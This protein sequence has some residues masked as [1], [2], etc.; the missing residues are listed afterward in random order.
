MRMRRL[1]VAGVA[2]GIAALLLAGCA[3]T[4]GESPGS[5]TP[6]TTTSVGNGAFIVETA[7]GSGAQRYPISAAGVPGAPAPVPWESGPAAEG[8]RL[9]DAVGPWALTATFVPPLTD[10]S[11]NTRLQVRDVVTGEMAHQLE[12]PGWCSGPDGAD[13][14][15]VLLDDMR[16]ARSTPLDGIEDATVTISSTETGQTLA[17]FGPFPALAAVRATSSPD[18]LV[19]ISYD[20][21]TM[22]HTAQRL[23]L[24]TG[25]TALIGSL[26]ISQPWLCVLG[27][28]SILTVDASTLRVLGP[29][30][31]AA[32][33]VPELD[34][35][36]PGA[37][38]CTP[39]GGYLYVRTDWTADPDAELVIDA[40]NLPDGSRTPAAL[41]LKTEEAAVRITR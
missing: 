6:S 40:I 18:T 24:G 15:C 19:L 39:D 4:G 23:D 36:G 3:G 1:V 32:V 2:S 12:V 25:D 26:P 41:T 38:G 7:D 34:G 11:R 37:V 21:A 17:E 9:L 28:D 13:Y 35:H 8:T 20:G 5:A 14:P 22:R 29:A 16:M 31:V 30:P 10:V 33:E 27:T